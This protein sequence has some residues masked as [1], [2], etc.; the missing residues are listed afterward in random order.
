MHSISDALRF[1]GPIW[2]QSDKEFLP[3]DLT[4]GCRAEHIGN[5]LCL[6]TFRWKFLLDY[7]FHEHFF[8]NQTNLL[9]V[10]LFQE[11]D[12]LNPLVAV[13]FQESFSP[14]FPVEMLLFCTLAQHHEM[15]VKT[16]LSIPHHHPDISPLLPQLL[17]TR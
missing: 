9:L 1:I 13:M 8:G 15:I 5:I 12:N 6:D 17:G 7:F 14:F 16:L 3:V 11:L 10:N 2:I 4:M